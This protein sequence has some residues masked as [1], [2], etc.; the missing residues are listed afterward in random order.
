MSKFVREYMA[1]FFP[2]LAKATSEEEVNDTIAELFK[3]EE[4]DAHVKA[5]WHQELD[6]FCIKCFLSFDALQSN[7]PPFNIEYLHRNPALFWNIVCDLITMYCYQVSHGHEQVGTVPIYAQDVSFCAFA[8][9]EGQV[10]ST[11]RQ[12]I[13]QAGLM[14][15][16]STPMPR[17]MAEP[18]SDGDWT[19]IFLDEN[20][21]KSTKVWVDFQRGLKKLHEEC[22]EHNEEVKTKEFPHCWGLFTVDPALLECSVS[23]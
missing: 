8:W 9:P 5:S 13:Q 16:T 18:G 10:C 7:K 12:A 3:K 23:V 21:N 20:K 17:L 6:A 19:H 11:K 14:A 15:F 2:L 1:I 4:E 22:V